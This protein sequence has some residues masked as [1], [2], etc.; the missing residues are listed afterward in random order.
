[1]RLLD[2]FNID[3]MCWE[4]DFPHSDGTWPH[5]PEKAAEV[6]GGLPDEIVAKITHENAMRHFLCRGGK[7][8]YTGYFVPVS[9]LGL[10]TAAAETLAEQYGDEARTFSYE[11]EI[12]PVDGSEELR[13][14]DVMGSQLRRELLALAEIAK[15]AAQRNRAMMLNMA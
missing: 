5:G 9:G 12:T 6:L 10:F 14:W 3:N 11:R 4:S 15:E 7:V 8:T 2:D 1:M 13:T